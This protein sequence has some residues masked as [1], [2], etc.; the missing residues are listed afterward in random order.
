MKLL[1]KFNLVF[2][3]LFLLGIGACGYVSWDMLQRNAHE[4]IAENA[5]LLMANAIAVRNY[6][7]KEIK[8]L[9]DTQI[10]YTFLPQTVPAFSATE[11]LNDLRR[12][13]PDYAYK[14]AMLNPTNPRDRA[15]EWEADIINQFRN[16]SAKEIFGERDTPSGKS[17]FFA[18]PLVV[19]DPACLVCHSTVEVAPQTMID[20]YGTANGFG[21]NYNET[22]GAQVVSV[23][24]DVPLAR[25]RGAFKTFIASLVGVLAIIG[26][27]LNLLLWWMFI[28]PVTRISALADR[29]SLGELDAPDLHI[30]TRDEMH[31]LAESLARMRK[32][33]V[34]AMKMLES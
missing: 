25:A 15:V 5:R 19:S 4:E 32:S 26:L 17:L 29:V 16:G 24:T 31:T 2:L 10:K 22:V 27:T 18:R 9:L 11:V 33:M 13:Y 28:R 1:V 30:N 12:K 21:W 8:P 6:T 23:P 20:K 34:Q 14:E 3:L 7:N